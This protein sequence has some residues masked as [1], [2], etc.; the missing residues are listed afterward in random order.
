MKMIIISQHFPPDKSG[1]ASRIYDL[2]KNLV[3]LGANV[4][5]YSPF[6][7]F[8]HGTFPKVN[9]LR[10]NR[11]IDG[12]IHYKVWN[13]QPSS[14]DPSFMSR[15]AYYL[16]FPL[17]ATIRALINSKQY[18]VIITTAPPVFTGIPGFFIKK[19]SRKKWL[20]D[21]RDLW[22]EASVALDFI[23]KD[24]FF[25]K[26]TRI[27]E[28]MCYDSCD[29]ILVTTNKVKE[30]ISKHYD[31]NDRKIKVIPNGVDTKVFRP[32]EKKQKNQL[33]FTGNIGHAQDLESVILAVKKINEQEDIGLDF[34]LVGDGDIKNQLETFVKQNN[35]DDH[36]FFTGILDRKEI[37]RV[38]NESLIG[39]APLK[40]LKTLEYAV[41]TKSYEYMACGIPFIG[42]GSGEIENIAQESGGGLIAENGVDSIYEKISYLMRHPEIRVEMGKSGRSFVKKH[43]D[44]KNI[45]K[46]LLD[47]IN[48]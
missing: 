36:V 45:A 24:G 19:I 35:I 48:S 44:R 27:Y 30:I 33:I 21:V 23:K 17:L 42:T 4:T 41:P 37:P 15:I 16:V 7:S 1:N 6:P 18:D 10:S 3:K 11:I 32:L 5:V 25:Y 47:L 22:L 34:H 29:E 39:I 12:I 8:P 26:I 40:K 43:Y 28:K 9:K 14:K 38:I 20:F 46:S 13:W 31:I 2:A